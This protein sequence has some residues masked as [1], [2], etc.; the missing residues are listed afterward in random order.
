[1]RVLLRRLCVR[2]DVV[3]LVL[4]VVLCM[5]LAYVVATRHRPHHGVYVRYIMH[6]RVWCLPTALSRYLELTLTAPEGVTNDLDAVATRILQEASSSAAQTSITFADFTRVMQ[7]TDL[8][9]FIPL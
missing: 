8:K 2:L 1:M 7:A 9:L 5:P 3:S 6:I 4:Y